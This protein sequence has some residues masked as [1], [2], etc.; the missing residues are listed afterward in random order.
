MAAADSSTAAV[1]ITKYF[2]YVIYNTGLRLFLCDL[3]NRDEIIDI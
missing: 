1:W 3:T 2:P